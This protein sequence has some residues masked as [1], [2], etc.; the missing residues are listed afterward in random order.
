MGA[1]VGE[2][3]KMEAGRKLCTRKLH[4]YA[5]VK[6]SKRGCLECAKIQK[7]YYIEK[8]KE[9][10]SQRQKAYDSLPERRAARNAWKRAN[11]T[12]VA[13]SN[14]PYLKF[15]KNQCE[16]CLFIGIDSCQLDVHHIDGNHSNN[17]PSNLQTLCANC[18]RLKTKL[19]G[20]T[21]YKFRVVK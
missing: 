10:I 2:E 9:R 13:L 14:K 7:K 4:Q 3:D 15:K 8:N 21:A 16:S 12:R 6:G 17:S 19:E 11:P 18:H 5:P 20:H 1:Q